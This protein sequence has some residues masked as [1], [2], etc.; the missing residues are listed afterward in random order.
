MMENKNP[1]E[2]EM[3]RRGTSKRVRFLVRDESYKISGIEL[4]QHGDRGQ[5]GARASLK[6][7][8]ESYGA[9]IVGHGHS[10]K[11]ERSAWMVGT[12]THMNLGYNI[13]ASSWLN[14]DALVYANGNRQIINYINGKYTTRKL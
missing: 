8:E 6:G 13:G 1:L 7:L 4:G 3:K 12:A 9:C 11:M 14:T 2:E 5:N 10:P